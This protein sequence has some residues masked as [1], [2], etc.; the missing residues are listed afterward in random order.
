M[1]NTSSY[2]LLL[3]IMYLLLPAFDHDIHKL[4]QKIYQL[5][6]IMICK[7]KNYIYKVYNST[8][9]KAFFDCSDLLLRC[10]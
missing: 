1:N 3:M 10:Y 5:I 9:L 8:I 7:K 2:M 4:F 6:T